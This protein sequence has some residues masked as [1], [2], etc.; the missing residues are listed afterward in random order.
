MGQGARH[1]IH[2]EDGLRLYADAG[3]AQARLR[4]VGWVY[5]DWAGGNWGLAYRDSAIVP[6]VQRPPGS[7]ILP[8]TAN[9]RST[10]QRNHGAL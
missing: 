4:P 3:D 10:R 5:D 1:V 9:F 7:T 6:W 8:F 2:V